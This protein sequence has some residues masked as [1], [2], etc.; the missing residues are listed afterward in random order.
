MLGDIPCAVTERSGER[1]LEGNVAPL[2]Q[3]K[4]PVGG[5]DLLLN[6][7]VLIKSEGRE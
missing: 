6:F 5:I 3:F 7:F 4:N 1:M 2:I